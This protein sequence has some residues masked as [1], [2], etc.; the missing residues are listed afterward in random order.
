MTQPGG[1][2]TVA[3][4]VRSQASKCDVEGWA[5]VIGFASIV[6]RAVG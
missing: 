4:N 6:G 5:S 1:V 2:Q 3:A